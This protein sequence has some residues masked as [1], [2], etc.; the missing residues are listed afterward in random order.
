MANDQISRIL[1]MKNVE[2]AGVRNKTYMPTY[3][4]YQYLIQND[5]QIFI[6]NP[7]YKV[8]DQKEGYETL[9]SIK[10]N[11]YLVDIFRKYE[12]VSPIIKSATKIK[13]KAIWNQNGVRNKDACNLAK[14]SGLSVV[15]EYCILRQHQKTYSHF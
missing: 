3:Q 1:K 9:K 11:I 4:P 8:I 14:D 7:N 13:A 2:M 15:L 10:S 12:H 5:Y 6:D